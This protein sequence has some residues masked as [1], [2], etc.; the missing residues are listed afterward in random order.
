MPLTTRYHGK[1][2]HVRV[3]KGIFRESLSRV[4]SLL[5]VTHGG[6][7]HSYNLRNP[8]PNPN[9]TITLT[10]KDLVSV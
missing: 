5:N 10:L 3:D 2:F 8:N 4:P 7:I 1:S 6:L 9:P